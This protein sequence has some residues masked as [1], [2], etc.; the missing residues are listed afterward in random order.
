MTEQSNLT[1]LV[2]DALELGRQLRMGAPVCLRVH[3]FGR[4]GA[5]EGLQ[6]LRKGVLQYPC[7]ERVLWDQMQKLL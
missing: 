1:T 3:D 7:Q 2:A 4:V 6:E 5:F